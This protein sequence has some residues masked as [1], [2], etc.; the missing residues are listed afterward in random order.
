[1]LKIEF[2]FTSEYATECE[3]ELGEVAAARSFFDLSKERCNST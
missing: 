1:M 2:E 3:D